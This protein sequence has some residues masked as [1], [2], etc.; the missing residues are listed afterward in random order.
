LISKKWNMKKI[1]FVVGFLLSSNVFSTSQEEI[2]EIYLQ[3]RAISAICPIDSDAA[4]ECVK[5]IARLS[6]IAADLGHAGAQV[7]FGECLRDARGVDGNLE[8]AEAYFKLAADQNNSY[9]Q[10]YYGDILLYNNYY[11]D[12]FDKIVEVMHYYKLS[13]DQGN[14]VGMTRYGDYL[15]FSPYALATAEVCIEAT[16]YLRLAADKG[17]EE[18]QVLYG[19]CLQQGYGVKQNLEEAARYFKASA[20]QFYTLGIFWYAQCLKYGYGVEQDQEAAE[21]YFRDALEDDP[22]LEAFIS[23]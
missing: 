6:Q 19:I 15:L 2:E 12:N 17:F 21:F 4:D 16:H 1:L 13:A 14:V 9:G 8:M 23:E 22:R 20:N 11:Y 5:E 10:V 7:L 18:A 3:A